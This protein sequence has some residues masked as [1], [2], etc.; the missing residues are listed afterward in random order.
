MSFQ[1]WFYAAAQRFCASLREGGTSE[2]NADDMLPSWKVVTI[3][4]N[5]VD[6]RTRQVM[7]YRP[8]VEAMSP[9][10]WKG[11]PAVSRPL[12]NNSR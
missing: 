6:A 9:R 11:W 12:S 7:S 5:T 1:D 10:R 2:R 3:D 4:D 8:L